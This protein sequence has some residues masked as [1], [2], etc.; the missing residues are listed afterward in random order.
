MPSMHH[1][2]ERA[3]HEL[4][5]APGSGL[6]LRAW[7]RSTRSREPCEGLF[8]KT[9]CYGVLTGETPHRPVKIARPRGA[10]RP[11]PLR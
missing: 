3:G 7:D 1:L 4:I 2:D 10:M 9:S 6:A 5:D 8:A 11:N